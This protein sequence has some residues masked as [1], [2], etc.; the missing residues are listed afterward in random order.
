MLLMLRADI[1]LGRGNFQAA[2]AHLEA[3]L[4]TL[5]ED[6]GQGIYDVF[7]AELALWERRW[8]EAHQ[9]VRDGLGRA[10]SHQ[11]AQLHV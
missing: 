8:T 5:R 1:E 10:R 4:A 11:G 3:A 9:A 2:R 7:L 6:R